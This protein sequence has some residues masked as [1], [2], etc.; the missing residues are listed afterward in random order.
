MYAAMADQLESVEMLLKHSALTTAQDANG[1]TPVHWAA[2]TVS[3]VAQIQSSFTEN[4]NLYPWMTYQCFS[5][6]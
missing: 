2:L 3:S 6:I 4:H 5:Q 1:Q